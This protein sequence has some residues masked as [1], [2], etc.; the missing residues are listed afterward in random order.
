MSDQARKDSLVDGARRVLDLCRRQAR[1]PFIVELAGTPK[2]GKTTVLGMMRDFLKDQGFHV[3]VM[4]ERAADCPIPMKGHFFFNAWT[5]ATMLAQVLGQL[6]TDCDVLLLDRGFF[7]ALVWL[8]LQDRRG[9]LTPDEKKIF[10]QFVLLD[11]W[12]RLTDLTLVLVVDPSVSMQ[13]E[14]SGRILPRKGSIMKPDNLTT[15][16]DVLDGVTQRHSGSFDLVRVDS[17][18]T[19]PIESALALLEK[20]LPRLETW[21]DPEVL[22]LPR[23][24]VASKF[25]G[26]RELDAAECMSLFAEAQ[27]HIV[28]RRR[29]VL[30]QQLDH[31]QLIASAAFRHQGDYLMIERS[32]KDVKSSRFG[33][34]TLWHRCRVQARE[35]GALL[36]DEASEQLS[37][38]IRDDFYL[39]KLREPALRGA[40]WSR[41]PDEDKYLGLMFL[42]EISDPETAK[43][44]SEKEFR[45]GER[46][47]QLT[48]RFYTPEAIAGLDKPETWSSSTVLRLLDD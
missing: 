14:N 43:S 27:P 23:D 31:V 22:A 16:N 34:R 46:I 26:K 28:R 47:P 36:L 2:A 8:E 6:D 24:F 1:R 17:K 15:Y 42:V 5:T 41:K 4:R 11:R 45:R 35:G 13:R 39:S 44:L 9:Q 18:E 37:D 40:V 21:A 12:R 7:D 33:S 10:E 20:I 3:S 25:D 48:T 29:S 30:D 32:S 38:R 19:G